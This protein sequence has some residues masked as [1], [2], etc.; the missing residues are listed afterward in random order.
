MIVLYLSIVIIFGFFIES[1]LEKIK[2]INTSKINNLERI[3]FSSLLGFL[4]FS[5]F[6]LIIGIL[7]IRLSFSLFYPIIICDFLYIVSLFFTKNNRPKEKNE[8]R[9]Y[10][11]WLLLISFIILFLYFISYAY[12]HGLLYPDEFSAWALNSKRIF[13]EQKLNLFL[14]TGLETYPAFL[15]IIYSS[16]YMFVGKIVENAIRIIPGI[17][18]LFFVINLFGLVKKHKIDE[19]KFL[20][21]IIFIMLT[22][23]SFSHYT[24]STYADLPF[25]S[26]Y[27]LGILYLFEWLLYDDCKTNM[28][29]S[30]IYMNGACWTKIDGLPMLVFN[31]G[32][33]ILYYLIKRFSKLNIKTNINWKKCIVYI[34][35][36]V[37]V[38]IIWKIYTTTFVSAPNSGD[39]GLGIVFNIQW[40]NPLL[41]NMWL[42]QFSEWTWAILIPTFIISIFLNW[43]NFD[44]AKKVYILFGVLCILFTILFLIICYL[45]QFGQE[46]IIAP[47][48]IRYMTRV[49][50]IMLFITLFSL[51]RDNKQNKIN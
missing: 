46:A 1:V 13:L 45:V 41:T 42:Q 44:D 26:F 28:I 21:F 20:F 4:S 5:W 8:K 32:I 2:I 47:S 14:N 31:F 18:F 50:F 34:L 49:L 15:P 3:A 10:K 12:F 9:D 7:G 30:I 40:L 43:N 11:F 37:F 51:K 29:L 23:T 6:I 38:G 25:A 17:I 36:I 48:Y 19:S 22:Y 24:F 27:T 16:F 35:G 39:S 33:L